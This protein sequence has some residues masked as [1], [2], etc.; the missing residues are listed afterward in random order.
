MSRIKLQG[1][2]SL[3]FVRLGTIRGMAK[4]ARQ[5]AI[6]K[7]AVKTIREIENELL[8]KSGEKTVIF[9]QKMETMANLSR[10]AGMEAVDAIDILKRMRTEVENYLKLLKSGFN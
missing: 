7:Q 5:L 4:V 6:A 2:V 9:K 1:T 10:R 3:P 8:A